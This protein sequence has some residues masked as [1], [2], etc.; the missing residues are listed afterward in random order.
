M[1]D[2]ILPAAAG[3]NNLLI[4][5]KMGIAAERWFARKMPVTSNLQALYHWLVTKAVIG[6]VKRSGSQLPTPEF[7][8]DGREIEQIVHWST[9]KQKREKTCCITT[10]ASNAVRIAH[11]AFSLGVFLDGVKFIVTGEPFTEFKQRI[12]TSV[13]AS[14]IPRY[15]YGGS[16]NVGYGCANPAYA[17]ELHVNQHLLALIP[18]PP[19]GRADDLVYPFLCTTLH[20][21]FPRLLVNVESGDYGVFTSR[22]CG[23]ALESRVMFAFAPCSKLR[24][25]YQRGHE[26]FLR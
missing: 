22:N 14:A 9:A 6:A 3:I 8:D 15:A 2:A 1:Y 5:A 19:R 12:I 10:A 21:S 25:I 24:K 16:I 4:Y 7:F 20:P 26:L 18:G 17:D 13:G 23:C 11:T